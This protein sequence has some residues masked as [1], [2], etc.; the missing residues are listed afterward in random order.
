MGLINLLGA[1]HGEHQGIPREIRPHAGQA[2][3][4]EGRNQGDHATGR[5]TEDGPAD[6]EAKQAQEDDD[7]CRHEERVPPVGGDL[8][9]EG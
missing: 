6:G 4:S 5:I 3:K 1:A 2:T 9:V 8:V 7:E